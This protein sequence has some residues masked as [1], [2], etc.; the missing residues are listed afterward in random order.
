MTKYEVLASL[1]SA[2]DKRSLFK[3]KAQGNQ[4][5]LGAISHS[6]WGGV[7]LKDV[8]DKTG[9]FLYFNLFNKQNCPLLQ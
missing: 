5:D 6:V 2:G 7:R 8:L 1:E 9:I 4:F 3:K